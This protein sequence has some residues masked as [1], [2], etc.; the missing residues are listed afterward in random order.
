LF[1][2]TVN[3]Y[4]LY[5]LLIVFN[6][7]A[8]FWIS[9]KIFSY[10]SDSDYLKVPASALVCLIP[11]G[12]YRLLPELG[13]VALSLQSI[14]L[15]NILVFGY[16]YKISLVSSFIVVI[17]S[18]GTHPYFGIMS[19]AMAFGG[20]FDYYLIWK[21]SLRFFIIACSIVIVSFSAY[22]YLVGFFSYPLEPLE[23]WGYG[24]F[25]SSLVDI[26]DPRGYDLGDQK[27]LGTSLSKLLIGSTVDRDSSWEGFSYLG[28]GVLILLIVGAIKL[29]IH[30]A[31]DPRYFSLS[32][33]R[34]LMFTALVFVLFLVS[35]SHEVRLGG[36]EV[37]RLADKIYIYRGLI[38]VLHNVRSSARFGWPLYYSCA[39]LC[40]GEV[41]NARKVFWVTCFSLMLILVSA[42]II[43][44]YDI[45]G[46]ARVISSSFRINNMNDAI[47]KLISSANRYHSKRIL[48]LDSN[49]VRSS[50]SIPLARAAMRSG[51]ATNIIYAARERT[52]TVHQS[53][54]DNTFIVATSAKNE[55]DSQ[56]LCKVYFKRSDCES[57]ALET[58]RFFWIEDN[59]SQ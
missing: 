10:Y 49:L 50:S 51:L 40:I 36:G 14:L 5:G 27:Y 42:I 52:A 46:A 47:E 8:T 3:E 59:L 6:Y 17:V 55:N 20:I 43:Q 41:I 34:N 54:F 48:F 30:V 32:V 35:L 21:K 29:M 53:H 57:I 23:K 33:G 39:Y 15:L 9:F 24:F 13:H 37:F 18:V 44:A 45:S 38:D 56:E 4:Q 25:S 19:F 2:R 26:F 22:L 7:V 16:K 12:V 11:I 28:L 31:V 1:I 58:Y